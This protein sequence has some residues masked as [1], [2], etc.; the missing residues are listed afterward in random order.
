[1][2]DQINKQVETL[3]DVDFSGLRLPMVTIYNKP[4]DFPDVYVARVWDGG[5]PRATNVVRTAPDADSLRKDILA[6]GFT[7]CFPRSPA[8]DACIVETWVW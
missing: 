4:R 6:A 7:I 2:I 1:M 3:C 8:D 5:G